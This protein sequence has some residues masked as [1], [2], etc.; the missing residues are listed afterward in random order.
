MSKHK[1]KN[2]A[3]K[4][5]FLDAMQEIEPS[6]AED[7]LFSE[8]YDNA[9]EIEDVGYADINAAYADV[10]SDIMTSDMVVLSQVG[11]RYLVLFDRDD[12]TSA[13]AAAENIEF[14]IF[15]SK[16]DA[17]KKFKEKVAEK[18]TENI[19]DY[20]SAIKNFEKAVKKLTGIDVDVEDI[21][22]TGCFP[23]W[24]IKHG[25]NLIVE[26]FNDFDNPASI[27]VYLQREKEFADVFRVF[28]YDFEEVYKAYRDW[29]DNT[30]KYV[31]S[32]GFKIPGTNE[33]VSEYCYVPIPSS[34]QHR[35]RSPF[36]LVNIMR[37]R[38]EL[39]KAKAD[40]IAD[41]EDNYD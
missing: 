24:S 15:D 4:K 18:K 14:S 13:E 6:L 36:E 1:N 2:R 5:T 35:Q 40:Y 38:A 7:N 17:E 34:L 37:M 29:G 12:Y 9:I 31:F 10:G 19:P 11:D 3:P 39:E 8:I 22:G 30:R 41:Q 20:K 23:A 32:F 16:D 27:K 26:Y 33:Y 21:G 28:G 25:Q